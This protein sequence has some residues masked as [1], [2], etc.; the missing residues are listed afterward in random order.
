M[1]ATG[2]TRFVLWFHVGVRPMIGAGPMQSRQECGAVSAG[3][4][5][6]TNDRKRPA[7]SRFTPSQ[8]ARNRVR[9][10]GGHNDFRNEVERLHVASPRANISRRMACESQLLIC[11][12]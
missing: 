5:A 2:F 3:A 11:L 1:K 9:Q 10:W 6:A 8:S 7:T 12:R 4:A